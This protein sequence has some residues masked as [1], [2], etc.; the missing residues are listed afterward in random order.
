MVTKIL[1]MCNTGA[2]MPAYK[3]KNNENNDNNNNK[4]LF[5]IGFK[6]NEH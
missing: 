3:Q 5:Y 4:T 6:N 2:K 1:L